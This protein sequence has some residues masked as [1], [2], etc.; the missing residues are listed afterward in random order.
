MDKE[1][2]RLITQFGRDEH[3]R[4]PDGYFEDFT[5]QLMDK[6]PEESHKTIIVNFNHS[7]WN[8]RLHGG[9]VAAIIVFA[10]TIGIYTYL[11]KFDVIDSCERASMPKT[12]HLEE[13]KANF[14][15][16][17]DYTMIDNED[18]YAS[19]TDSK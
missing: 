6:L 15:Q 3:F 7:L 8:G 5:A 9:I 19:L 14:D 18:I 1:E 12:E 16:M 17:A 10:L 4:V 13:N 2:K 11:G